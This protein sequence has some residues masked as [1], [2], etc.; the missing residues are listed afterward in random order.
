ML[1]RIFFLLLLTIAS[2]SWAEQVVVRGDARG[3]EGRSLSVLA[4]DNEF[5]EKRMV[6]AQCYVSDSGDF[7]VQFDIQETQRVYIH[8]QR[9]E[10]PLYVQGNQIYDVVFP[11]YTSTDFK[12]FDNTEV[13]LQF[14]NLPTQDVNAV[15]RKFN[16]DYAGFIRDHFYDFASE[17]YR[18]SAE[19]L[20][21]VGKK[22][23]KVDL[24]ARSSAVDTLNRFSERG[25]SRLV[26]Q[27]ED[28]VMSSV[29]AS[30]DKVFTDAYKRFSLAE[31]H[32]LSGMERKIL[33]DRYF[34]STAPLYRNPAYVNCFRL[35][36]RNILTGQKDAVQAG[37]VRAVNIDRDLERL[38]DAISADYGLQ[39]LRLRQLAAISGL[40]DVYFNKSFDRASIDLL[41]DKVSTSDSLVN[42]VANSTLRNLKRGKA[43]TRIQ[44]FIFSDETQEKWTLANA[45]GL[46]LYLLFYASWSPTS[47]KEILV[48]ERIQS[49]FKG[50]VQF[51]AVCMDDEYR[52]YRKY[53]E[54]N[55]KLPVKLLYGNAEPFV[56]EKF[57]VRAIPHQVMLDPQG[58]IVADFCPAPSDPTFESF[59]NRAVPASPSRQ[60]QRTW[61]DR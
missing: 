20:K 21:Y 40:K 59:I 31:L 15:I 9:I 37:I 4:V 58:V 27:F 38:A 1:N 18:G 30:G 46:P 60:G 6:L 49:K 5:S 35:L 14:K 12:R 24:Y 51:V 61:K 50:R 43:G 39:S 28:S 53:L 55:L 16:L 26:V 25:F 57:N 52:N 36:T 34:I 48:L 13:D 29:E 19:Y 3:Y 47:L 44:E 41:L 32:L 8:I 2:T 56:Y 11:Q 7:Q 10:A 42:R 23:D 22:G 33:Y 45:D 54:E 17:E